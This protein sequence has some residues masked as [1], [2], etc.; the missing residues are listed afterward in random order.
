MWGKVKSA[1]EA[2]VNAKLEKLGP[3]MDEI[4]VE[5]AGIA[6]GKTDGLFFYAEVRGDQA[7]LFLFRDRG[8]TVKRFVE[9]VRLRTLVEQAW[10]LEPADK[11]WV[12]MAFEVVGTKFD[13]HFLYPEQ[14][15]FRRPVDERMTAL[16]PKRFDGKKRVTERRRRGTDEPGSYEAAGDEA[17][18]LPLDEGRRQT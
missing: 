14:V 17:E 10:A 9:T 2:E 16:M 13:T 12:A 11:R 15:D 3:L 5:A 4:G 18:P 6:G 7:Q 1:R 8:K